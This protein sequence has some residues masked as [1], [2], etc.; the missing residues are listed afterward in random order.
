MGLNERLRP[1]VGLERS[2]FEPFTNPNPEHN[3]NNLFVNNYGGSY[4]KN[5]ELDRKGIEAVLRIAHLNGKV[6]LSSMPKSRDRSLNGV[7]EDG[8]ISAKKTIIFDNET[9]KLEDEENPLY[10]T[11]P[12]AEGWKIEINDEMIMEELQTKRFT[13][14]KHQEKFIQGFNEIFKASLFECIRREK[15]S[16]I[17]DSFF[18]V[19]RSFL[20]LNIGSQSV[21][22]ALGVGNGMN[23]LQAA[24]I[25]VSSWTLANMLINIYTS[26]RKRDLEDLEAL[27]GMI[28]PKVNH[29]SFY[30][31][32]QIDH[33]WEWVMPPLEVDKVARAFVLLSLPGKKLIREKK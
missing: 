28:Y 3:P 13:G 24:I 5:M 4:A 16:S 32:R 25:P 12:V 14:K 15:L 21:V 11:V 18:R 19:K 23:P 8:S 1:Q 29:P 31:A 9:Q 27:I 2:T 30:A 10:R 7:N 33:F 6:F 26:S 22:W 17:K 20:I